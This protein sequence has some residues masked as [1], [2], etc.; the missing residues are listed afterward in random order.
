MLY[1]P[2]TIAS[3]NVLRFNTNK[4][5]SSKQENEST[6]WVMTAWHNVCRTLSSVQ[7]KNCFNSYV[8]IIIY[9]F[10]LQFWMNQFLN[11]AGYPQNMQKYEEW[12][13]WRH[14]HCSTVKEY[15]KI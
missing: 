15:A 11:N 14:I 7:R 2:Y 5:L 1:L 12:R 13:K 8:N 9:V 3:K 4:L 6:Q 10:L